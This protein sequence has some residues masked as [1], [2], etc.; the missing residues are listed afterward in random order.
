MEI[1]RWQ[2]TT[3]PANL[4]CGISTTPNHARFLLGE[5]NPHRVSPILIEG[6]N[7]LSTL[8]VVLCAR[9]LAPHHET[10]DS[11]SPI[12]ALLVYLARVELWLFLGFDRVTRDAC[13]HCV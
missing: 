10:P 9:A 11:Y 1:G 6:I 3:G 2:N 12:D 4:C 5:R 7:D 8:T 13:L